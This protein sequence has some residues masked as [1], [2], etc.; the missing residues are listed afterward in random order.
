M[1]LLIVDD[2][3]ITVKGILKGVNWE[4][5]SFD[6]VFSCTSAK[7]AKVFFQENA[8]DIL[9]SDIEMP[10]ESGLKL[11][12]WVRENGYDTECVF[13][14]C[15]D[16]FDFA[17]RA[18]KLDGLDYLLKPVPYED[19][20]QILSLAID[21]VEKQKLSSRYQEY[22]KNQLNQ[23][24]GQ[25]EQ[26]ERNSKVIVQELKTYIDSHL[27][28]DL[29]ADFLAKI[30][31]ISTPYLFHIF[32]KEEGMTLVEYIT[33]TRMFCAAELLKKP[34]VSVTR[35]AA[36][37]GYSNYSYFTKVFKKVHGVTPTQYHSRFAGGGA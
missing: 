20:Q 13:L 5:L 37:V 23:Y 26:D 29:T 28:D 22:G 14:T 19:L 7:E 33:N 36:N 9:L 1:N 17:Q 2:E 8:I 31:F 4:A 21:K 27:Q 3:I 25:I 15:H 6:Q 12:E 24:G 32:K 18:L 35:V 10:Q 16:K 30:A 11:L 34:D